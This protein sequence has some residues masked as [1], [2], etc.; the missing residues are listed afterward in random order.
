M[1]DK[2]IIVTFTKH[3]FTKKAS[4][5]KYH[6][7]AREDGSC[8]SPLKRPPSTPSLRQILLKRL[9]LLLQSL[10]LFLLAPQERDGKL[11]FKTYARG[12]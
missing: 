11:F 2:R 7:Q 4:P 8:F 3:T 10:I 12:R 1:I 9:D 6:Y 5:A